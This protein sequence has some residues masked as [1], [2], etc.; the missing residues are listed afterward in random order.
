MPG[1]E[2]VPALDGLRQE[3]FNL[4]LPTDKDFI[5]KSARGIS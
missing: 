1:G 5:L 3:K 2:N 4:N